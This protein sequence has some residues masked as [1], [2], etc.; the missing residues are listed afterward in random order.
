MR[1]LAGCDVGT[2]GFR[3]ILFNQELNVLGESYVEYPL[4]T[5]EDGVVEQD[6]KCWLEL[7]ENTLRD[8]SNQAGVRTEDIAAL[9]FSSQ[10]ITVVP[11][12]REMQPMHNAI[13]W[14][15]HR[16]NTGAE[17]V[18]EKIGTERYREI[19]LRNDP[20]PYGLSK[21]MWL[22]KHRED[23]TTGTWK[24]L[25]PM[26]FVIAALTG[27]V[28]TDYSM[29]AGLACFDQ[30]KHCWSEE[31]LNAAGI[32]EDLLPR[33]LPSGSIAGCV[34]EKGA[35]ICGLKIGTPVIVGAQDQKCGGLGAGLDFDT[36]TVSMGTC[37]AA[38]MKCASPICDPERNIPCFSD[39]FGSG[40]LLEA[41]VNVGAGC[42][43]WYRDLYYPNM[44]YDALTKMAGTHDA[45][46]ETPMFFPHLSGMS[47][48]KRWKNGQAVFYGMNLNTNREAMAYAVL[49][50]V[51]FALKQN[52]DAAAETADVRLRRLRLFGGGSRSDVWSK[53]IADVTGLPVERLYT[54]EMCCVGAAMLAGIGTGLFRDVEHA[55]NM[56]IRIRDVI[57][58]NESKK[59]ICAQRY[60]LYEAR[61]NR[62]FREAYAE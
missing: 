18:L 28:A 37:L 42:L 40:Y 61:E 12:D 8:A 33:I 47:T 59:Q 38:L 4:L 60:S 15:D 27:N 56:A 43:K 50:S 10:G 20:F 31:I 48:P 34:T 13:S 32:W 24:Y 54:H 23:L 9:S 62:I 49:E 55:Q 11:V 7:L 30:R 25:M 26:D 3:T 21:I 58:P 14:L 41:C 45:T 5:C 22:R 6:A 29:A 35:K 52:I 51:A 53:I 16:S 2:T 44:D 46:I 39:I 36:A 57:I 17:T 19:T 1:I